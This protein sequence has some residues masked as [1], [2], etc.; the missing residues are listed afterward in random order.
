M[1]EVNIADLMAEVEAL[2]AE[3][4][5]L[6]EKR[7]PK[8]SLKVSDKGAVSL[9]GLGRFPVTLYQNQWEKV[10]GHGDAIRTFIAEN[11]GSLAVKS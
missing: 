9:Y 7:A 1:S 4:A 5:E 6:K 11:A 8:L 2:K 10:L 3:N